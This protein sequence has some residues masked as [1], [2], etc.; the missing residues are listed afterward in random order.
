MREFGT[1]NA[2]AVSIDLRELT[3]ENAMTMPA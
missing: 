2:M 3:M 1:E